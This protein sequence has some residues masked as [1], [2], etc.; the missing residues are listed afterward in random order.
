MQEFESITALTDRDALIVSRTIAGKTPTAI[1]AELDVSVHTVY[2]RLKHPHVR[3]AL[4]EART[5][6]VRPLVNQALGEVQ[7][8][9]ER[10]VAVR[11]GETTRDGDRIRASVAILDWFRNVWEMA[12]VM[13]RVANLESQIANIQAADIEQELDHTPHIAHVR[14]VPFGMVADDETT[15]SF[16]AHG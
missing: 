6:E 15:I 13:P 8:S 3:L 12:E 7:K 16:Q 10:L 4:T 5:G 9:I 2:R 11:D 14:P 1:A